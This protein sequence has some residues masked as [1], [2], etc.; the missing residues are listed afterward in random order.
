MIISEVILLFL[1]F[2][3]KQTTRNYFDRK[4][5]YL[6]GEKYLR[7]HLSLVLVLLYLGVTGIRTC[8]FTVSVSEFFQFPRVNIKAQ[9]IEE[10]SQ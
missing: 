2:I 8:V 10:T 3:R 7:G 1:I 9:Q 5:H 6:V 4:H